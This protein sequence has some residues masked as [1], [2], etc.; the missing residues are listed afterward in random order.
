MLSCVSFFGRF[1]ILHPLTRFLYK[2]SAPSLE[3]TVFGIRFKNPVGMA[4]GIDTSGKY[5]RQFS[6]MGFGFLEIG[7]ITPLPQKGNPTP[8]LFLLP[9][10]KAVVARMGYNND[11]VKALIENLKGTHPTAVIAANI[12]KND[13]SEGDRIAKDYSYSFSMLYDF[14]DMFII[15]ISC[16]FAEGKHPDISFLSDILDDILDTRLTLDRYKP[17]LLKISADI[18]HSQIDEILN[19]AL[20][21]GIDGIVAG[22]STAERENLATRPKKLQSIGEGRLSG[23]PLFKKNLELVKYIVEKTKGRLPV[24]GCGGIMT[25]RDAK[26]MLDAGASLV[27]ICSGLIYNGPS[28]VR[29]INKHLISHNA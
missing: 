4:A 13:I 29:K 17:V 8:R 9:K 21:S 18:G 20:L 6:D 24:I 15:N 5:C 1:R 19:Y 11:G 16:T 23:A 27:E 25:P 2:K 28:L 7:S 3:K 22:G 26:E 12:S 14:V 10:D